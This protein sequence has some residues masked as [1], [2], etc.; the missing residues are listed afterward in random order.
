MP[1]SVRP[2]RWQPTRLPR[3]WDSPSKN[4]GVGQVA[5]VVEN[6]DSI[7][8]LGRSSGGGHGILLVYSCLEN[9]MDRGAWQATIHGV[10]KSWT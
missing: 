5:L 3:P 2:R 10:E 4:T 1:D 7:P 6:V 8:E 9:S